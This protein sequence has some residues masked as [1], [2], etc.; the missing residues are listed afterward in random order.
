MSQFL[1]ERRYSTVLIIALALISVCSSS[2]QELPAVLTLANAV[3]T[4]SRQ[5]PSTLEAAA[6]SVAAEERVNEVKASKTP[7]IDGLW[8]W[9]RASR[10]NVFGLLLPQSVIP[11]ISGPVLGTDDFESAW[12][13]AAGLLFSME[14]FDFGRRSAAVRAADA[15]RAATQAE[16]ELARLNAGIAAA[17]AYLSVLGAQEVVVAANA[18]V[19]RLQVLAGVIKAQVDAELKPGADQ[20]RIDAEFASAKNR[21]IAA[22]QSL[23]LARLT[24][25]QALGQP[26]I[27]V[28]L[29]PGQ[30]LE[31][32]PALAPGVDDNTA[33]PALRAA[34]QFA[35]AAQSEL[36]AT[37][38]LFRPKI[39]LNGALAARASGANLNGTIDN[40]KGLVP[41]VPNWAA[42]LTV[43]FPFLDH[44]GDRARARANAA[45]LTAAESRVTG[46]KQ[47]LRTE[48]LRARVM[49]DAAT[50][51][52]TNI[53]VQ[54]TAARQ[55]ELQA[56]ARYD[57]GLTGITEVADA[58]RLLAQAETEE[59]I[60]TLAL[61]RARLAQASAAGDLSGFLTEAANPTGPRL[62]P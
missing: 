49:G 35:V 47:Q 53:P 44:G 61:W 2:A 14:V 4:A 26:D 23:S 37:E 41:D 24:L 11:A 62:K 39:V 20:S 54:L 8:Q 7:R 33:N 3:D 52:A 50:R 6:R 15:Q 38:R 18:N 1:Y 45:E 58:Q 29:E 21:L 31:R 22:E 46:V 34:E 12:G 25:A 5:Y 28:S 9:N 56:R 32:A 55:A 16:L 60:A 51:M 13:S 43:T 48:T 36:E 57:A 30:L 40:S 19:S 59:A 10:N 17:D 42:G 27:N